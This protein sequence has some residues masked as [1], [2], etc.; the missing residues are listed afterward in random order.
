MR[1]E[2][3]GRTPYDEF[4]HRISAWGTKLR[5]W[6]GLQPNGSWV[7]IGLL[8]VGTLYTAVT[9]RL[10]DSAHRTQQIA[11]QQLEAMDRPWLTVEL[12]L[13][14]PTKIVNNDSVAFF[15]RWIL[16]NVGRSVAQDVYTE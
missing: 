7:Q 5:N 9:Y 8:L 4:T 10:L 15:P 13:P 11:I 3:P 16:H 6:W 2:Q 1:D 12:Q 14:S